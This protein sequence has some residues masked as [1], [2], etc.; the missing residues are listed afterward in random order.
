MQDSFGDCRFPIANWQLSA[1]EKSLVV[2]GITMILA[3]S[4]FKSIRQSA[5][6]NWQLAM[7]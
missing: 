4:V 1:L 5:I 3:A 2:K 7:L 6:G